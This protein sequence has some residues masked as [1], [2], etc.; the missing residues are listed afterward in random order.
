MAIDLSDFTLITPTEA[1][2]EYAREAETQ[3]K[4]LKE[5]E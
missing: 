3:G 2:R 5:P 4:K 1:D